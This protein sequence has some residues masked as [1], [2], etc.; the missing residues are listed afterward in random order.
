MGLDNWR[1]YSLHSHSQIMAVL[2]I[3]S[4][5]ERCLTS[6]AIKTLSHKFTMRPSTGLYEN[7]T[8]SSLYFYELL[9]KCSIHYI[10]IGR[11]TL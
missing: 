1:R 4:D 3:G 9:V 8:L 7:R 11:V 6:N 5:F 10:C 2:S